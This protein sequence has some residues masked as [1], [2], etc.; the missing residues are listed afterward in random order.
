[1]PKRE[2]RI[3]EAMTTRHM[4]RPKVETEVAALLRLPR[5]L[6]PKISMD[7]PRK[8]KPWVSERRGQDRAK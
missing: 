2:E 8:T 3:P 7:M 6:K 1:M 5:M 4:G